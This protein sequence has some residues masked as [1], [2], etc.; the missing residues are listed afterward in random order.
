MLK[1]KQQEVLNLSYNGHNVFCGVAG[2]GKSYCAVAR[3]RFLKDITNDNVLLLTYN[4][5]LIN[6]MIDR[7]NNLLSDINIITYHKF[8][9][10]CMRENGLLGYNEI[11]SDKKKIEYID[12]AIKKIID[13]LGINSTLKRKEFIIEEIDWMQKFGFL[14][15]EI[16]FRIERTGRKGSNIRLENRKYIFAVYEEYINIRKSKGYKYDWSDIAY[17][18]NEVVKSGSIKGEYK[19]IIID[20]AQ[21]FSPM[22]IQSIVNYIKDCGSILYLGDRAQQIY[23]KGKMSWKKLGL[24]ISKVY[25]LEENHRN[26]KQIQN[27]ANE[28]RQNLEL[29]IEDGYSSLY[30][31]KNGDKPK[32]VYFDTE[33]EEDLYLVQ[34]CKELINSGTTCVIV[35]TKDQMDYY[36]N[37]LAKSFIYPILIDRDNKIFPKDKQ[38]FISTFQSV[39]GLEFDN[40]IIPKCT[41]ENLIKGN[42]DISLLSEDELEEKINE[43]SKLIYVGIT[44]AKSNLIITYTNELVKII[45]KNDKIIDLENGELYG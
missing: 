38:V 33:F 6:Y 43:I 45:P 14:D 28:I 27:F 39:K 20:E 13:K 34:K 1:G 5:S 15:K 10:G 32:I 42:I 40:V 12:L 8:I 36:K 7:S 30:S 35:R 3:A 2:S 41:E 16:Y 17:Y 26:S 31:Y 29:D 9:T 11:L 37:K 18:F 25:T 21:D 23:G 4:N 22:M 24:K 19:H 44:R